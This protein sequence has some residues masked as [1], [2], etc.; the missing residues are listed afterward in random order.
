MK[1]KES[2]R[3]SSIHL[4]FACILFCNLSS[5]A[6]VGDFVPEEKVNKNEINFHLGFA[7]IQSQDL[8]FSPMIYRGT[9]ARVFGIAYQRKIGKGFHQLA[10]EWDNIDIT[11]T[12]PISFNGVFGGTFER[13]SSEVNNIGLSYSYLHEIGG[14]EKWTYLIGGKLEARY[15]ETKYGFGFSERE[16]YLLSNSILPYF[17]TSYRINPKNTLSAS[18][19]FPLLTWA[20]RPEYAIVDNNEI[21]SDGGG[22]GFLY[23]KGDLVSLGTFQMADLSIA[24]QYALSETMYFDLAYRLKYLRYADPLPLSSLRNYLNIGLSFR[25]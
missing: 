8:V 1:L 13:E 15:E 20:A 22:A 25:F 3:N 11:S 23:G 18:F 6:Q 24:Y 16:G 4:I 7:N 19:A 12:D 9:S 5:T 21:K 2:F 14:N 10:F 17:S